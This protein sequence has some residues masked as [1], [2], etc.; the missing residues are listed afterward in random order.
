MRS[1]S[2]SILRR[3]SERTRENSAT[4]LTGLVRKSSAPASSPCDPVAHLVERRHHDDRDVRGLGIG[5]EPAADF[6][7]VHARHHD[8]EQHDVGLFLR[9]ASS[10]AARRSAVTTS[11][12]FGGKLGLEE[13]YV[14]ANII[15]DENAGGH[16]VL[17]PFG[18]FYSAL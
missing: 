12:I 17:N 6:E 18:I 4:S 10:A 15:D 2:V 1:S 13:L 11:I 3:T 9:D 8:V 7:T 5:L 16:G 14:A